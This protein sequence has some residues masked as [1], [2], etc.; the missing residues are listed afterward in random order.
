MKQR[1]IGVLAIALALLMIT[2]PAATASNSVVNYDSDVAPLPWVSEEITIEAHDMSA[3]S[4][5]AYEAD[6][7]SD[8]MIHGRINESVDNPVSYVPTDVEFDAADT[9]P[10]DKDSV[11]AVDNASEWSKDVSGSAGSATISSAETAPNVDAIQFSTSSQT[12]SDVATFSF[13][14]FS[15]TSDVSKRYVQAMLDVSTLDSGATVELRVVDGDGDYYTAEINA[16]RSSGEDLIGNATGEGLVYQR[17]IGK[18]S[19]TSAGDGSFGDI[20][21]VEVAVLDGDAD[22]SVSALTVEKMSMWKLGTKAVD[23]DDDDELEDVEVFE[24][25]TGGAQSVKSRASIGTTFDSAVIHGLMLDIEKQPQDLEA[26]SVMLESATTGQKYPS[27]HGT[28]TVYY[29]FELKDAYDLSHSNAVLLDNQTMPSDRLLSV[30]MAEGV[31]DDTAFNDVESWTDLTPSYTS[32]GT[33]MTVDDTLQPGSDIV[34]KYKM[35]LTED[36]WNAIQN[37]GSGGGGFWSGG[38]FLGGFMNWIA[39]GVGTIVASLGV[40]KWVGGGNSKTGG[41]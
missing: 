4:P 2:A 16:S 8:A 35:K 29:R 22:V 26:S 7:G 20:E 36:E 11:A 31:S 18:M 23:N 30:E 5:L 10:H 39:A 3:S 25:K 19:L 33:E 27:Y 32:E 15:V 1:Y 41:V 21:E 13:T 14:N 34:I 9:F 28:V 12:S 38:G 37:T 6:D 17:Q 40:A 24:K